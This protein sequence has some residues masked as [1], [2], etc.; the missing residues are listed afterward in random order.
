MFAVVLCVETTSAQTVQNKPVARMITGSSEV[1][2]YTRP[3]RVNSPEAGAAVTTLTASPT[4]DEANETERRAFEVT[5]QVRRQNGLGPLAWDNQLCLMARSHSENM[6]RTGFFSH[7]TQ[8]GLRLR[9]RARAAGISRYKVLGENIAYNQG[10]DDP[11]AFAVER[12][13]VSPGHRGNILSDEFRAAA[14]GTFLAADGTVYLTQVF[15]L[16]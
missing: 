6:A 8:E 10:F 13:M 5:N 7:K 3:R 15:I 12:W 1:K 11:G 14:I 16:R 2:G 9:Q 4:F